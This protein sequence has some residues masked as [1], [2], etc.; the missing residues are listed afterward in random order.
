MKYQIVL[1]KSL[2]R[3]TIS[4]S[5]NE[6]NI[7]V[8]APNFIQEEYIKKILLTKKKWIEKK[9][10]EQECYSKKILRVYQDDEILFYFGKKYKLL[11]ILSN[12]E[13][14]QLKEDKFCVFYK[15]KNSNLKKIIET[16]YKREIKNYINI[17]LN[18]LAKNMEIKFKSVKIVYF[19]RRLGSCSIN[20]E[21]LFNWKL[22]M[23][24]KD[25]INYIIIHELCHLR[26]FNHSKEFWFLVSNYAPK[27]KTYNNWLKKNFNNMFW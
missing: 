24:P 11:S 10:K 20:G 14:I 9:I 7:V 23:I 8:S 22:I 2:K 6:G 21:L 25:I 27:Y 19:K 15:R 13:S 1:K 16:W 12:K 18:K 5:V 3:K 4:L 26:H 17:N